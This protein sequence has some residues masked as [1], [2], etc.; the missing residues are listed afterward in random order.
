MFLLGCCHL[1]LLHESFL[2][3]LPFSK[4]STRLLMEL[5]SRD[6]I[7]SQ[8]TLIFDRPIYTILIRENEHRQGNRNK[9]GEKE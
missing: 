5:F 8:Y 6:E 1:T 7:F 2:G 4:T 3:F 9:S